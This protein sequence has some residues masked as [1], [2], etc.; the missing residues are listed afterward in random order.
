MN[1]DEV[2]EAV[3]VEAL[4]TWVRANVPEGHGPLTVTHLSGG[5]SNLTFRV[6][7]DANDWVLRRP[8]L[9]AFLATA[10]DMGREF[11]VQQGL[12]ASDVPVART[13]AMC[14]DID[15]IGVPFYLMTFVDGIVYAD[16]DAV[17]HLDEAQALA[18]TDELIDVLARLHAV[19]FEAVGLGDLGR[20]AGFLE[21]QVNRWRTQWEKSK[22]QE[23]PA[24]DEVATRL[25]RSI[26][27]HTDASIVH[28]DYSFN[29]TM[30]S[31]TDPARMVAVLDWEMSTLGDPLTDL[32]MVTVYWEA[33]GALM[34]RNR[35]P[36]PH[37]L[38]AGF[39]GV[40]HLVARY[41]ATSGRSV[42]DIDVYRVLAVFKLAVITEG[43]HARI[44]ATRPD[45][46]TAQVASTVAALA[47]LALEL[48]DQSSVATL[49]GA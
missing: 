39:P 7:D 28:G 45:E 16:A 31:R 14:E 40:D 27:M 22:Q 9:G 32:G 24:I 6:R 38:N 5:S 35:S 49:R 20:P 3:P 12:G 18:A 46:D 33:A 29:N 43:A 11:R 23:L 15:V 44:R 1:P 25:E 37:R 13:V 19:D 36:Q 42:R 4:T 21:R 17:D 10:N 34:W 41:E 47:D 26:P 2:A 30:W 8:P 48:A